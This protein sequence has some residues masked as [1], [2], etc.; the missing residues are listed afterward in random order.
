MSS[1]KT[2]KSVLAGTR[3]PILLR[4][5]LIHHHEQRSVASESFKSVDLRSQHLCVQFQFVREGSLHGE[6]CRALRLEHISGAKRS[7]DF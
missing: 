7:L 4:K 3:V 6:D 5:L 1:S 2:M